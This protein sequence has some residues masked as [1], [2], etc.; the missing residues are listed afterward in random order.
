MDGEFKKRQAWRFDPRRL[1]DREFRFWILNCLRRFVVSNSGVK[2]ETLAKY[3]WGLDHRQRCVRIFGKF[4]NTLQQA[5]IRRAQDGTMYMI[6]R[7]RFT[8]RKVVNKTTVPHAGHNV[9]GTLPPAVPGA[10]KE[11]TD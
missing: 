1:N 5:G 8:R 7:R 6:P 9:A 2:Y 4:Q 11:K 10:I 3:S